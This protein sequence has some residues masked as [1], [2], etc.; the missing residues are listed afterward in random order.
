MNNLFYI[1]IG[2]IIGIS[3]GLWLHI[4]ELTG[5]LTRNKITELCEL[6]CGDKK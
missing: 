4:I 1:A 2:F 3:V 6:L 5:R